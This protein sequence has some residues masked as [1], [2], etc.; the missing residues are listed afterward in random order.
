MKNDIIIATI[1]YLENLVVPA[2][3]LAYIY[4]AV[5]CLKA[6]IHQEDGDEDD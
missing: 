4:C 5:Q 3:D 1:E 6:K 2:K